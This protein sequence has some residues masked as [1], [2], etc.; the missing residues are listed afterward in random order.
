[1][2]LKRSAGFFLTTGLVLAACAP[3][4]GV[5]EKAGKDSSGKTAVTVASL[6][7]SATVPVEIAQRK[8][9]FADEGLDVTLKYVEAAAAVPS[10]VGG[11]ADFTILNAPAVLAARSNGVPVVGVSVLSTANEDPADSPL[12]LLATTL[13]DPEDLEGKK[14]AV[15]TLFQLPDLTLRTALRSKGVDPSEVEFVEIPF[16]QMKEALTSGQ[17]VAADM[18][19][20]FAT[21]A[22]QDK[23]L[24]T[25]ISNAE[26]QTTDW[27]H[28]VSLGSEAFVK[29]NP[30]VVAAFQRAMDA[31]VAYTRE[32][33]D[34]A[35]AIV[36]TYTAVPAELAKAINMP[37]WKSTVTQKGWQNWADVLREEGAVKGDVDVSG[38]YVQQK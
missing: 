34:E 7:V 19:E 17:V 11:E 33:P 23:R 35:R 2:L 25:L 14:V 9:F 24:H 20:P 8:G 30:E 10:V 28:T 13:K 27:P 12:R 26:G 21:G 16:P 4:T 1:M 5:G 37:T 32:H 38:A 31:A 15:D 22:E 29:G 18:T 6:K 3:G 36:P